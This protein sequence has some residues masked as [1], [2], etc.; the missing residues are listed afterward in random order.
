MQ[1]LMMSPALW[2]CIAVR[3]CAND[4]ASYEHVWTERA[5]RLS[6]GCAW[7]ARGLERLSISGLAG[8]CLAH[9][10]VSVLH[11]GTEARGD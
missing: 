2:R 6:C 10:V 4:W 9:A 11:R 3:S 1:F 8:V 5:Q 7:S